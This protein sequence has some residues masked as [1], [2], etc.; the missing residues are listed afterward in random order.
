MFSC[1]HSNILHQIS[2]FVVAVVCGC[3]QG[4]WKFLGQE[5][6]PSPAATYTIETLDP[7]THCMGLGIEPVPPQLPE[8]LQLDF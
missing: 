4:T 3:T 2:A 6:N 8:P 7:L 1:T 5:L